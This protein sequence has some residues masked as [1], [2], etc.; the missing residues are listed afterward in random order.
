MNRFVLSVSRCLI[1]AFAIACLATGALAQQGPPDGLG[2]RVLNTPLSVTGSVTTSGTVT[3]ANPVTTVVNPATSPALTSSVDDPGRIAYQTIQ[4]QQNCLNQCNLRFP[5][6]PSGHRLVIQHVS[7]FMSMNGLPK[8]VTVS[9]AKDGV[10]NSGT[11]T[12]FATVAGNSFSPQ[13]FISAFDQPTQY[14]IDAAGTPTIIANADNSSITNS[15]VTLTGYLLDC[16]VNTCTP[17]AP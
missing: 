14:Y 15:Q 10:S 1:S 13:S 3:V 8:S 17:I 11:S 4:F 5:A 12:F 2:V 9:L 7:G 16:T 6:V